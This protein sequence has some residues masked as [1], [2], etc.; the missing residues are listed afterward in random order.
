MSPAD[1]GELQFTH[2]RVTLFSLTSLLGALAS[3]LVA[4]LDPAGSPSQARMAFGIALFLAAILAWHVNTITEF[5]EFGVRRSG[6]LRS[7]SLA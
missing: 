7:R 5:H 4:L 2:L 1:L 6:P 3:V